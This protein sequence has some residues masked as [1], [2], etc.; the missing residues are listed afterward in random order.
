MDDVQ[1]NVFLS[2]LNGEPI[3]F[4]VLGIFVIDKNT[5]LMVSCAVKFQSPNKKILLSIVL[6][7]LKFSNNNGVILCSLVF[8]IIGSVFFFAIFIMFVVFF[9][10]CVG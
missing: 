7:S 8:A 5:I 3:G 2:R 6:C 10:F 1:V 4:S 9:V